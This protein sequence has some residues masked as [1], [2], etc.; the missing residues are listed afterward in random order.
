MDRIPTRHANHVAA[1]ERQGWDDN[2]HKRRRNALSVQ[3]R[4]SAES[5]S[6][7]QCDGNEN[8]NLVVQSKE[9]PDESGANQHCQVK[10]LLVSAAVGP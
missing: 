7:A 9:N 4:R 10:A 6:C 3:H 8:Q 2:C 1:L 5:Y